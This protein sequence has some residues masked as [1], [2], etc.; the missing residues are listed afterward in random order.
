[1]KKQVEKIR[2]NKMEEN[3]KQIT[4]RFKD[5]ELEYINSIMTSYKETFK[6]SISRHKAIKLMLEQGYLGV[7][8]NIIQPAQA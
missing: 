3:E 5:W 7:V 6:V 2:S 8:E 1:M 4:V